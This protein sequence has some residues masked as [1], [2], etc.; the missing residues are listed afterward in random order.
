MTPAKTDKLFNY[1]DQRELALCLL[2][3]RTCQRRTI[4]GFFKV[5]SRLGDGVFWYILMA[6]LPLA[7]GMAGLAASIHMGLVSL[8]CLVVYKWLKPRAMRRRPYLQDN[9]IH[10]GTAPL[11]Y[12]SFPSGHTMHAVAFTIAA[13]AHFPGLAWV[14]VPFSALI[15]L[16][17]VILGLHYPSDVL[18]GAAIGA[19]VT[20]VSLLII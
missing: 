14:L 20:S 4:H 1:M 6:I 7:Q 8:A 18:I 3:N 2:V 11:D 12:Y 13:L 16:S 17:R 19:L 5:A 10:L 9:Q 15:A